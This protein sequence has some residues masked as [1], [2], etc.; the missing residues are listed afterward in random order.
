MSLH[1][2]LPPTLGLFGEAA[3]VPVLSSVGLKGFCRMTGGERSQYERNENGAAWT[4]QRR[5]I[6]SGRMAQ[7][8]RQESL[9]RHFNLSVPREMRWICQGGL[10]STLPPTPPQHPFTLFFASTN[11]SL[12]GLVKWKCARQEACG[13]MQQAWVCLSLDTYFSRRPWGGH[14]KN[15]R[16][17]LKKKNLGSDLVIRPDSP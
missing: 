6:S 14:D 9:S 4:A 2:M 5:N 15:L 1:H 16:V 11:L 12:A 3:H 7:R 10:S 13:Y 8:P 17:F